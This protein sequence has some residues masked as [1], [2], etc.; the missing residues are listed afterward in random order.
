MATTNICILCGEAS[1]SLTIIKAKGL[2]TL[3]NLS[4]AKGDD[5]HNRLRLADSC[6][7]HESCRRK[8]RRTQCNSITNHQTKENKWVDESCATSELTVSTG[9]PGLWNV[10][11]CG[12]AASSH[13]AYLVNIATANGVQLLETVGGGD[14]FFDAIRQGLVQWG[15]HRT[16]RQLRLAAATELQIN[17]SQYRP[18]YT[19][20]DGG[21]HEQAITYE[22]FVDRTRDQTEWATYM[23][24]SAMAKALDVVIRVVST[25]EETN[26]ELT[27]WQQDFAD[28]VTNQNR[29][30]VVGYNT[31]VAHYV[32][33]SKPG[34]TTADNIELMDTDDTAENC[35]FDHAEVHATLAREEEEEEE[36]EEI[37]AMCMDVGLDDVMVQT[38]SV[39]DT[40]NVNAVHDAS[41]TDNSIQDTHAQCAN[42]LRRETIEFPLDLRVF[43]GMISTIQNYL[44]Y[45]I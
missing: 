31:Q 16:I 44:H 1:G 14:C 9:T 17:A 4:V 20:E 6:C 45:W 30:I 29:L 8:Y 24:V 34:L 10:E 42:C 40:V 28:G 12:S 26:S 19:L 32:G 21:Q 43:S 27:A 41:A 5:L 23:T 25:T 36:E 37:N 38:S 13:H 3:V 7:V 15:M 33:F 18:L 22:K 2:Q 11:H 39:D 35:Q